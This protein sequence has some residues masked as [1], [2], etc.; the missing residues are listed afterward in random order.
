MNELNSI[1]PGFMVTKG[2]TSTLTW[3]GT[4][5]IVAGPPATIPVFSGGSEVGKYLRLAFYA[6]VDTVL[7]IRRVGQIEVVV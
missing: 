7:R 5:F 1:Q 6:N 4:T 3:T 2:L